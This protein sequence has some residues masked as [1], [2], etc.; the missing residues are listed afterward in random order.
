MICHDHPLQ[1]RET[2]LETAVRSLHLY[3]QALLPLCSNKCRELPAVVLQL[4]VSELIE[5]SHVRQLPLCFH[6]QRQMLRAHVLL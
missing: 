5:G 3:C 4:S 1:H 6:Q 2:D